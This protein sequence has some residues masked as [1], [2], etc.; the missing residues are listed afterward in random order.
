MYLQTKTV[1]KDNTL[2]KVRIKSLNWEGT[3]YGFEVNGEIKKIGTKQLI[4]E[5]YNNF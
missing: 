5:M 3:I 1:I 4:E 2:I